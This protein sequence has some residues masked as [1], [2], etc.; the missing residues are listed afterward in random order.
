[1]PVSKGRFFK[2]LIRFKNGDFQHN[3]GNN[4][5]AAISK[6]YSIIPWFHQ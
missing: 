2:T 3:F 5:V 6:N 4:K 1:M